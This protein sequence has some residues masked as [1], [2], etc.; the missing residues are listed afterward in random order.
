MAQKFFGAIAINGGGT[1]ALDDINHNGLSDDDGALVIDAANSKSYVYSYTKSSGHGLSEDAPNRILP[2]S[3]GTDGYWT[4]VT[5][6]NAQS[7]VRDILTSLDFQ[8][9]AQNVG[10]EYDRLWIP[11]SAFTGIN[12]TT[13]DAADLAVK[14]WTTSGTSLSHRAYD[15]TQIEYLVTQ[16]KMPDSW[17]RGTLRLKIHWTPDAGA[18][19]GDVVLWQTQIRAYGN[20]DDIDAAWGGS[21]VEISDTV[22]SGADDTYHITDRTGAVTVS[23]SAS[24]GDILALYISRDPTDAADTMT[25]DA[26]LHGVEVEFLHQYSTS[27]WS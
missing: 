16:I 19:A 9:F 3:D 23:P 14:T 17:N 12:S 26:L 4:L 11:S 8:D 1:G 22:L 21:I 27:A 24:L 7:Y 13:P 15:G 25:E 18:S 6:Q 2:D 10:V 5:G 20:G